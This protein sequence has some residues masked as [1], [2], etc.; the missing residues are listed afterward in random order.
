[1]RI[2]TKVH[3][4]TSALLAVVLLFALLPLAA[5]SGNGDDTTEYSFPAND[6]AHAT[7][8]EEDMEISTESW[9]IH[10]WWAL[11]AD[12]SQNTE[13]GTL[14]GVPGIYA[15]FSFYI[16]MTHDN[17]FEDNP[18]IDGDYQLSMESTVT[19]N[20][21]EAADLVLSDLLGGDVSG[22]ELGLSGV[23]S[24]SYRSYISYADNDGNYTKPQFDENGLYFLPEGQ[25]DNSRK[26]YVQRVGPNWLSPI[27]DANG[28]AVQPA[29]GSYL[30]FEEI[31]MEYTGTMS[32]AF[33]GS[34]TEE[35]MYTLYVFVV[36]EPDTPGAI[37]DENN[38]NER[39]AKV[40]IN[41]RTANGNNL[42][43]EGDGLLYL[44]QW[45]FPD[46]S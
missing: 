19:I 1:M 22:M 8:N 29:V 46:N 40:Y 2:N 43:I 34:F 28:N 24:G 9:I 5:C 36:I 15:D 30:L 21:D 12:F 27:K 4:L 3:K 45:L 37:I 38:L 10:H 18:S 44:D 42:W 20:S 35:V 7:S 39:D 23:L 13:Y 26:A 31:D 32:Q 14:A 25:D 17:A 33:V 41:V 11:E 16:S 6:A